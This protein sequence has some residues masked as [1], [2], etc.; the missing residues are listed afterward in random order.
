MKKINTLLIGVGA[1]EKR[2]YLPF[3]KNHKIGQLSACL[4]IASQKI[5]VNKTLQELGVAERINKK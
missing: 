2:I 4:D 1:H 3:M 5:K